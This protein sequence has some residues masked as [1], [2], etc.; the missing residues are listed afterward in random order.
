[1]I[2]PYKPPASDLV[3]IEELNRYRPAIFWKFYFWLNIVLFPLILVIVVLMILGLMEQSTYSVLDGVDFIIWGIGLLGVYGLAWSKK[4]F[5]RKF[6]FI[7]SYG[8]VIWVIIYI[9]IFPY[10][11][12][13]P[14]YGELSKPAELI[15]ELP[16]TFAH[17]Y[18]L[19]RYVYSMDQLWVKNT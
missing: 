15:Y 4:I 10:V 19:F 3:S 2:N 13:M 18:A 6:W 1:M 11:L 16:F 5:S 8:F 9:F 7:F 12:N 17:I 14:T